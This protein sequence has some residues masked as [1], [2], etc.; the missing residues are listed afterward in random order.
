MKKRT[1]LS[2][3]VIFVFS[4]LF[5]G[6][7]AG[8]VYV[9]KLEDARASCVTLDRELDRAQNKIESL[10]NTNH[11]LKNLRDAAIGAVAFI[12]PPLGIL[13]VILMISDSHVA[14]LAETEA[15]RNR[16]NGMVSIANNRGCGSQ[17]A[18][19]PKP[20]I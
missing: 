12:F 9:A 17:L 14:D 8:K 20:K 16:H 5:S 10:E 13:N 4:L 6:C 1:C 18:M 15:L 7:A 19:I 3:I 2:A 11:T